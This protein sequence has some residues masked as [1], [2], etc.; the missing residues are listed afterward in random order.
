MCGPLSVHAV[1]SKSGW[2]SVTVPQFCVG[3]RSIKKV[4]G[5]VGNGQMSRGINT[6]TGV[7]QGT[8][9]RFINQPML[10]SSLRDCCKTLST[11]SSS[12]CP[13]A[14][15]LFPFSLFTHR[16]SSAVCLSLLSTTTSPSLPLLPW[17]WLD[18]FPLDLTKMDWPWKHLFS[19]HHIPPW[20][21]GVSSFPL[22]P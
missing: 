6:E 2:L 7:W 21:R 22:S 15:A 9:I 1:C 17:V 4:G 12:Q 19:L 10:F 8:M 18:F 11:N 16:F 14:E 5:S 13:S 20:G 3:E